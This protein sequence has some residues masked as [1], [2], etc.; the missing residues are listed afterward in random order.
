MVLPSSVSGM[1]VLSGVCEAASARRSSTCHA[2]LFARVAARIT[3]RDDAPFLIDELHA[4]AREARE[5]VAHRGQRAVGE[6]VEDGGR[7]GKCLRAGVEWPDGRERYLESHCRTR[8]RARLA[9]SCPRLRH[10]CDHSN[11]SLAHPCASCAGAVPVLGADLVDA[12]FTPVLLRPATRFGGRSITCSGFA[13]GVREARSGPRSR[14]VAS[15]QLPADVPRAASNRRLLGHACLDLRGRARCWL[16]AGPSDRLAT[17]A[18]GS[19]RPSTSSPI[20]SGFVTASNWRMLT[21]AETYS[22]EPSC[23]LMRP[24]IAVASPGR[25]CRSPA[26]EAFLG[27]E[28]T[29]SSAM[30]F[31]PAFTCSAKTLVRPTGSAISMWCGSARPADRGRSSSRRRC[32]WRRIGLAEVVSS[33]YL[34][35]SVLRSADRSDSSRFSHSVGSGLSV[36]APSPGVVGLLTESGLVT[37]AGLGSVGF[38]SSTGFL[39]GE[40]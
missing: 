21:A 28:V 2:P 5:F 7:L 12:N 25:S 27:V 33:A 8:S 10:R 26:G 30:A 36:A 1:V 23:A 15:A 40:A 20:T 16:S 13:G 31:S 17:P 4:H 35:D 22:P 11:L 19:S 24:A 32:P 37:G 6:V 39:A 29:C 14:V 9:I 34:A 18:R 3:A 38:A